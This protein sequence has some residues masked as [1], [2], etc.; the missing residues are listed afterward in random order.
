M[1]IDCGKS[2]LGDDSQNTS[3]P[4]IREL[5]ELRREQLWPLHSDEQRMTLWFN[6][7]EITE[8]IHFMLILI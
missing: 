6:L 1:V 8:E 7:P 2:E 3:F 5:C 4:G